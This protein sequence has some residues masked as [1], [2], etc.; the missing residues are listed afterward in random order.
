MFVPDTSISK[1][2][3]IIYYFYS[4][5][6]MQGPMQHETVPLLPGGARV[7]PRPLH[8]VWRRPG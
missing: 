3:K 6:Q 1:K 8:K 2:L 5:L 4:R 7:R